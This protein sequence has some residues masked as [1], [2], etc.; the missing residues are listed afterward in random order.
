MKSEDCK[1]IIKCDFCG[2]LLPACK[3]HFLINK[4]NK[5]TLTLCDNCYKE[6]WDD[7]EV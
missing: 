2:Q 5:K 4:I 6:I 7:K 1:K 3:A